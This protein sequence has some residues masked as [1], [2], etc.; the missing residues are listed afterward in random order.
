MQAQKLYWGGSDRTEDDYAQILAY[1]RANNHIGYSEFDAHTQGKVNLFALR[2]NF[3]FAALE[4]TLDRI[5]K[6]LPAIKRIFA[7]PIIRL[8]DASEIQ[9]VESVH[10]VNHAT[11]VHASVH[12]ELWDNITEEGVRPKKLLTL[13]HEDTYS[14]Y[15]NIAFARAI[16]VILSLIS[17][18][19]RLLR[20]MLYANRDMKFNLLERQNHIAY[21]LAI[22]K[23]HIGYVHDYDRYLAEAERCLGKL[24]FIDR[25]IRARLNSPVYRKCKRRLD[26]LPL[27]KTNIFRNHKDYHRI[28]LLLKWFADVR[29]GEAEERA[30]EETPAESEGYTVYCSLMTL[31]AAG[32]FNFTFRQTRP[33][34]FFRLDEECVFK[35]WKLKIETIVCEGHSALL[36]TFDKDLL[37]SIILLPVSDSERG[38]ALLDRF[39]GAYKA[40]EYLLAT[41]AED[42]EHVYISLFDIES[43][44]R[45]QQIIFSGMIHADRKREV[46]PFCGRALTR[47]ESK[48]EIYECT[49]CRTQILHLTC[50]E[51]GSAFTATRIK[52]YKP[53]ALDSDES[54]RRD[55]LLYSRLIEAQ[56]HFRNITAIEEGGEIVCPRCGKVH[57]IDAQGEV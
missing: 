3:D 19:I 38:E 4:E 11:V 15:E 51:K 42:S 48:D 40:N 14:I 26:K 35:D 25:T 53:V 30:D 46:C 22:G 7:K 2:E 44:R 18:N 34:D 41:P 31:F 55:R 36:F 27:K 33:I 45:I 6:T 52:N 28:Y 49:A 12:S 13:K 47:A 57:P 32:H 17:R 50:P 9:P 5:T 29:I 54:T 8:R 43:F 24:L 23:L 37:Y 39:R 56:M 10:V 16:D 20:D 21:F 1:A